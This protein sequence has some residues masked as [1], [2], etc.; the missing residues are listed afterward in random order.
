MFY[1]FFAFDRKYCTNKK[2]HNPCILSTDSHVNLRNLVMLPWQLIW[3]PSCT[4]AGFQVRHVMRKPVLAIL[5]Q[6]RCRS[7]WHPC[8]LISAFVVRCLDSI[9]P[10][11]SSLYLASVAEQAGS[12]LTCSQTP[13]TGFLMTSLMLSVM[14]INYNIK[15]RPQCG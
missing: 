4:M 7:T 8:S 10:L 6:Q 11:V 5:E 14:L 12:S 15:G 13:K 9:I 1:E 2:T 3:C